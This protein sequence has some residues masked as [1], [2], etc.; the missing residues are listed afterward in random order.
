MKAEELTQLQ[1]RLNLVEELFLSV[2]SEQD[3]KIRY[4]RGL[5]LMKVLGRIKGTVKF[6][7]QNDEKAF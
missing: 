7:T 5:E 1:D 3:A 2:Y 4:E 6:Y